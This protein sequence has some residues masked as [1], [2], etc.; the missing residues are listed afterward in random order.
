M[1]TRQTTETLSDLFRRS[2]LG[3]GPYQVGAATPEHPHGVV[4]ATIGTSSVWAQIAKVVTLP[5]RPADVELH[6]ALLNA[7]P[8]LLVAAEE[9]VERM[10]RET[11]DV[12]PLPPNTAKPDSE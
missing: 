1:L 12:T 5:H 9:A 4:E 6:A 3:A 11:W 7:L 8:S 10:E 2:T